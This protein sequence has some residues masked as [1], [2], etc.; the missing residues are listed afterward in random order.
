MH[1]PNVMYTMVKKCIY[2]AK[3]SF[4]EEIKFYSLNKQGPKNTFQI[5]LN[6]IILQSTQLN[7]LYFFAQFLPIF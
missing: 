6:S 4:Q 7:G 3:T 2:R 1:V 5:I